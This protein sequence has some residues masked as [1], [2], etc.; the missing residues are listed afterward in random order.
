[1]TVTAIEYYIVDF[2][3]FSAKTRDET[4]QTLA[5]MSNEGWAPTLVL[6]SRDGYVT[7]L[8]QRPG[9][10]TTPKGAS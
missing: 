3:Y 5:S 1:M 6:Y 10:R 2:S 9:G 7:L 8:L 4:E